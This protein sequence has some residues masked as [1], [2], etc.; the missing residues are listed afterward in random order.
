MGQGEILEVLKNKTLTEKQISELLGI[1]IQSVCKS[2][3]RL[4]K[5]NEVE[6]IPR[7]FNEEGK[8]LPVK[9]YYFR[10]KK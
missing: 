6:R 4:L 9:S 1:T 7:E 5:N 10:I 8:K 3:N 2:L